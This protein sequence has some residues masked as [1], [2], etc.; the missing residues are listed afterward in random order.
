MRRCPR[1]GVLEQGGDHRI[2]L[3]QRDREAGGGEQQGVFAQ[4]RRG[5]HGTRG[6]N[7]LHPGGL[8]EHLSLQGALF[9]A[10]QHLG[11]IGAELHAI[12]HEGEAIAGH[13]EI[14]EA[15]LGDESRLRKMGP[16]LEMP[17]RKT[18]PVNRERGFQSTG[19]ALR[20]IERVPVDAKHRH[21][22]FGRT[23]PRCGD[24][25]RAPYA[26]ILDS[27]TILDSRPCHDRFPP[28]MALAALRRTLA[29]LSVDATVGISIFTPSKIFAIQ[30]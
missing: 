22:R 26:A 16:L 28:L 3:A 4:P 9:D 11:K 14:Q 8:D 19:Q 20:T 13:L 10:W 29:G 21:G 1:E 2:G 6:L 24:I 23:D 17:R 12:A 15:R 18:D 27:T 25:R 30:K 5:V 7:A